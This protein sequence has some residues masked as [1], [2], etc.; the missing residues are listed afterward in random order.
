MS[1]R[2]VGSRSIA[3]VMRRLFFVLMGVCCC[4][5]MAACSAARDRHACST[6]DLEAAGLAVGTIPPR[7]AGMLLG[8]QFVAEVAGLSRQEREA[9]IFEEITGGNIPGFT[10]V[11]VPINVSAVIDDVPVTA[12][13]YVMPDY[14]CIGR[15]DDFA[16]MPMTPLIAQP[17]A[18]E[19]E[20][21]LP[22]RKMVDDIYEH[23]EVKPAPVPISPAT[24]DITLATTFYR[25][26]E[27]IEEQREGQPLGALIGG[28]KKDVVITPRLADHPGRVAIYG[29]HQLNGVP[30]QPLYL[31]HVDWYVDYSHGIRL[32]RQRMLVAGQETTVAK[33]LADPELHVLLSD[34]GVVDTSSY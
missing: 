21:L 12:T 11:F 18:D 16:R 2:A 29:W 14:L 27:L 7:Q 20:C 17:I 31:G 10:R 4:L 19:F 6:D 15:D 34:E 8:S 13:Y 32:V 33:V 5:G 26:H 1:N 3:M 28:I 22:T 24:V 25:H 30:I 23:A 9:R